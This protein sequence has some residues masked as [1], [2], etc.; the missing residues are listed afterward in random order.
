MQCK[1]ANNVDFDENENEKNL[2]HP[3]LVAS[4]NR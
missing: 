1:L 2:Y 3:F 4:Q